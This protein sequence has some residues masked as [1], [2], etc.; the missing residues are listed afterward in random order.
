MNFGEYNSVHNRTF[1]DTVKGG[2][3]VSLHPSDSF[4]QD[5]ARIHAEQISN[6]PLG[7]LPYQ[8]LF[9]SEP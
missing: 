9:L 8:G 5:S 4:C 6:A 7:I 1:P 2:Y 3:L